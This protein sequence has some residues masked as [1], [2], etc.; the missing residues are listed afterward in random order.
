MVRRGRVGGRPGPGRPRPPGSLRGH[1]DFSKLW[2]GQAVSSAGSQIT[3]LALPLTA[4]LY[5]HASPGQVGLLT[6]AGLA[7]Y[8]GPS[9]LFGVLADRMRRRP[10][11]I[12]ADA[13]RSV[14]LA[15]VP[16]LAWLHA[17]DM[18]VMYAVAFIEGA[19]SVVFQVAYRSYLPGLV[20]PEAL[21]EGNSKLQATQ[22][23]AQVGGPGLSGVLV[24]LLG[25]P[26][27]LLAD[28]GSFVVSVVSLLWIRVEEPEPERT[29][30]RP[31]GA[32]G[33]LSEIQA[34]LGFIYRSPVLR[35]L[36]GSAGLFNF[37]SQIQLTIYLLYAARVKHMSAGEIGIIVACFGVGG[38]VASVTVRRGLA[39]LGYGRTLLAGYAVAAL[40][41]LGIPLVPGSPAL[42]TELFTGVYFLAGYGI[43]ASS[44]AMTTLL[45]VATPSALQGRVNASF[46][47]AVSALMPFSALLA[48]LLG[49]QL[50]LRATL[51]V[52]AAGMP[53]SVVWIAFSPTRRVGA[54]EE[55]APPPESGPAG[56][57]VS[58]ARRSGSSRATG[59]GP[60]G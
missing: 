11:M 18:P 36:A 17:L 14:M 52:T 1:A 4:V 24:G 20:G 8:C 2:F 48:G 32:R 46:W 16:A 31:A 21:L 13:G 33:V 44:I 39:R 9:L 45:Q 7:A 41:I 47:F 29:V 57:P 53:L 19:L 10:L 25:A 50:G 40:A 56:P 30:G 43:V 42:S 26:F 12:V 23:V 28:A 27:A 51:F 60:A 3:L 58:Q 55:L 37:F 22:S 59:A 54:A 34:G 38:V 15:V 35:A 49:G 6:A 5:L